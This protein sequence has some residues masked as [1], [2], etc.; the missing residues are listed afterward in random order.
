MS[1]KCVGPNSGAGIRI[2]R[3]ST[4][5]C[6][7]AGLAWIAVIYRIV[8]ELL[9]TTALT[10]RARNPR[11][12]HSAGVACPTQKPMYDLNPFLKKNLCRVRR[13]RTHRDMIHAA[14]HARFS[15]RNEI[16]GVSWTS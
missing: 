3:H 2:P 12:P 6:L 5:K 4:A 10:S 13:G 9:R 8:R 11:K 1:A 15:E 7:R 16:L 14:C